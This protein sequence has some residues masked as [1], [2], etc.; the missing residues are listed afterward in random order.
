MQI[1][2]FEAEDMT[3]A[4]RLVKRDFGDDAVILSAKEVRPGGF[5][6]P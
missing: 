3:E 5:S 4:L 6:V 2:R 1:K